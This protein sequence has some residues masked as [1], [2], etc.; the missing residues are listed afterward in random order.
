[1]FNHIKERIQFAQ[2]CILH[3]RGLTAQRRWQEKR[4]RE[5]VRYAYCHIPLWRALLDEEGIDP[6]SICTLDDLPRLPMTSKQTFIGKIVEEY[7]DSSRSV[8]S[9]WYLTSGTSGT[10]FRFLLS[11]HA[12]LEKYSN[13]AS[14]RF[15]WWRGESLK[16]LASVRLAR[17][18]IRGPSSEHRL[19]VPV[20]S[21]LKDPRSAL[22]RVV[23]FKAEVLSAY[24]SILF[25]IA[26]S[27]SDDPTL[28]RPT[29]RFALSFGEMLTPSARRFVETTL[30]CEVYNRYGLEEVDVVGVECA[31]H[32]G[33]H[34]NTESVIIEITD[35]AH[36]PVA[37]GTEGKIIATDLFN[38]GMP[39]I[40][41]DTGD[42]GVMSNEPCPCG[43]RS[44]RLWVKGRYS[45]YLSFPARRIHHLEFDGAMD[46]FM[47][48]VFQYQI[49]K[50]SDSEIVARII[51]GPA[52]HRDIPAQI[53]KSLRALVGPDIR[54]GVEEVSTISV[55]PRGKSRIVVDE[56]EL[57]H[58]P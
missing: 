55:T 40:R 24:P 43:L 35:D 36:Q 54:I 20:E 41:Y 46:G 19:F 31:L 51:P 29:P 56:S 58:V 21:Y 39:F 7:I 14:L 57:P 25:D 16:S 49:A 4:L 8:R 32:E 30:G 37:A 48:Y 5:L 11:E 10:P 26:R 1:M 9:F 6:T 50:K 17:I 34:I 45:A 23:D 28:P 42:Y 53:Q 38:Y 22:N 15:L 27:V 3:R 18:K 13:F 44:P 12:I 33:F 2:F 52:F 47:N